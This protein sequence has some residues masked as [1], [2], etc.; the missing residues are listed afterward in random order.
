MIIFFSILIFNQN[1]KEII[2]REIKITVKGNNSTSRG[3]FRQM[4]IETFTTCC[5]GIFKNHS[6]AIHFQKD[7]N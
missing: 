3:I 1:D 7:T 2:A 5:V 4:E 6:S